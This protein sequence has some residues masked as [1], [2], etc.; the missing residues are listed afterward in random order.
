MGRRSKECFA[1]IKAHRW[2][3][4]AGNFIA[5]LILIIG[6]MIIVMTLFEM[7]KDFLFPYMRMWEDRTI[8]IMFVYSAV[9]ALIIGPSR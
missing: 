7:G 6:A 2:T 3:I 4:Q 5:P 8:A 1:K 9:A